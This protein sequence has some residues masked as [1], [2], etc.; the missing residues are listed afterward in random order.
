MNKKQIISL[1]KKIEKDVLKM[2]K[3]SLKFPKPNLKTLEKLIY[4]K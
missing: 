1:E 3:K 4:E 2:Y